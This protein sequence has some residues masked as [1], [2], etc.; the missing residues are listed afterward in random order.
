MAPKGIR[1][2]KAGLVLPQGCDREYKGLEPTTAWQLACD[3]ARR[4]EQLGFESLWMYDHFQVHPPPENVPI[5]ESFVSLAALATQTSTIRLGHLVMAA[6]FR[7]AALTAKM[8]STLD[9]ISGGR[10]TLGMGAGWKEDEWRAYGYGFPDTS[11]RLD[12]LRDHLEII[13][14]LLTIPISTYTG[15]YANVI[16][17]Y[18]DPKG[19]QSPRIPIVVGGNGPQRTWR[20]A[21][22]FADELNLDAMMP[23]QI[24]EALPVVRDRCMEVGRDPATLSVAV[25]FWG[26]PAAVSP[27]SER[28]VRLQEYERLGL[29]RII[30]ELGSRIRDPEGLNS[31]AADCLSAGLLI[32]GK[33]GHRDHR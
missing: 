16:N 30:F 6:A 7:N 2:M 10:I 11:T 27:G 17:A 25:H 20:L 15:K 5:F 31:V 24:S 18:Q 22:L 32:D 13:T 1:P 33:D 19:I 9:V 28:I 8:I 29:S 23:S 3:T 21:A 12:I 4:A 26:P 14:R